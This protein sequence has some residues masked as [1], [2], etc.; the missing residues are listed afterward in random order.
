MTMKSLLPL[1]AG[2]NQGVGKA[3]AEDL[4]DRFFRPRARWFASAM[5]S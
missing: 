1:V 4:L 3:F 5:A 2:A